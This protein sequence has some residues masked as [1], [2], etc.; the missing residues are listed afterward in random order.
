[1]GKMILLS[2]DGADGHFFTSAANA[3]V[4]LKEAGITIESKPY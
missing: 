1:M 2:H 4:K 3:Q